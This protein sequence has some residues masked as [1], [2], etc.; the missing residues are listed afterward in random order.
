LA[1]PLGQPV[2]IVVLIG[3]LSCIS[4]ARTC[5]DYAAVVENK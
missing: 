5:P 4:I 3:H 2:R 1:G